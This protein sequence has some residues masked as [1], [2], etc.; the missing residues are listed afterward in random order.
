MRR[1]PATRPG[2]QSDDSR[3]EC[4]DQRESDY[5][6]EPRQSLNRRDRIHFRLEQSNSLEFLYQ[7]D[8]EQRGV[9]V[10][11]EPL[12]FRSAWDRQKNSS[13][14]PT[15]NNASIASVMQT[16]ADVN[17]RLRNG[18]GWMIGS[19]TRSSTAG[20][21]SKAAKLAPKQ[22]RERHEA[23]PHSGAQE[24]AN[25]SGAKPA[26]IKAAPNGSK[27]WRTVLRARRSYDEKSCR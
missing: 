27:C 25:V 2:E 1:Q 19:A 20:G 3:E 23:Q 7:A 8:L 12:D 9:S 18:L 15:A 14:N 21:A 13:M 11:F 5:H 10:T 22:R 24:S 16:R 17:T 4:A 26:A 6:A